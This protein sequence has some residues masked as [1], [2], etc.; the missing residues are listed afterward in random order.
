[1]LSRTATEYTVQR[2]GGEGRAEA[3][4]RAKSTAR[5]ELWQFEPRLGDQRGHVA[6]RHRSRN[7]RSALARIFGG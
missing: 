4:N 3:L 2:G 1:L 6:T 7:L 5:L